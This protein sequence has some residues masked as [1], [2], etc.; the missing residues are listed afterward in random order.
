MAESLEGWL[1][2]ERWVELGIR[3]D[4]DDILNPAVVA[5]P[6]FGCKFTRATRAGLPSRQ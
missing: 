3:P 6:K 4:G 2:L 5:D 1:A